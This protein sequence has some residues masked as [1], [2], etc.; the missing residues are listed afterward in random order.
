MATGEFREIL[1]AYSVNTQFGMEEFRSGRISGHNPALRAKLQTRAAAEQQ[2]G[3]AAL[4]GAR[5]GWTH[6]LQMGVDFRR[7]PDGKVHLFSCKMAFF[8]VLACF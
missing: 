8:R 3:Q 5:P 6:G 4:E 1:K 2:V 7:L